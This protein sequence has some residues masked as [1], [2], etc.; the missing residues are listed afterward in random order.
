[1]LSGNLLLPFQKKFSY[2]AVFLFTFT[3]FSIQRLLTNSKQLKVVRITNEYVL[4]ITVSCS[5]FSLEYCD[6]LWVFRY[7]KVVLMQFWGSL[8]IRCDGK[9]T[10]SCLHI[11]EFQ[12]NL[13]LLNHCEYHELTVLYYS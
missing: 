13:C 8:V 11:W 1:M 6:A 4:C 3:D 9:D 10:V 5:I 12:S 2:C 7:R